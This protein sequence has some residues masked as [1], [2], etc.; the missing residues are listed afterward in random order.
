MPNNLLRYSEEGEPIGLNLQAVKQFVEKTTPFHS[1]LQPY[2]LVHYR[3]KAT[4]LE[5]L[6]QQ[7][8]PWQ[9]V[10]WTIDVIK[11]LKYIEQLIDTILEADETT[12]SC[13]LRNHR[14]GE[15]CP[16]RQNLTLPEPEEE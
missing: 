15:I 7:A 4:F 6:S 16:N 14:P 10:L 13:D 1:D 5:E 3:A 2:L 9:I 11:A 12:Y 8:I